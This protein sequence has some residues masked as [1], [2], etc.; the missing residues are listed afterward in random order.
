M[1]LIDYYSSNSEN[2]EYRFVFSDVFVAFYMTPV[3]IYLTYATLDDELVFVDRRIKT[4]QFVEYNINYQKYYIIPISTNRATIVNLY[5]EN[6]IKNHEDKII[7][8]LLNLYIS[9][10]SELKDLQQR[11]ILRQAQKQFFKACIEIIPTL[12]TRLESS[13]NLLDILE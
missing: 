1:A 5:S 12:D 4:Y 10:S 6:N 9:T 8:S 3:D 2:P 11:S 13:I 7:K